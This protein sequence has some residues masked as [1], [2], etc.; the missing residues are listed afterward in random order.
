MAALQQ[1]EDARRADDGD[2]EEDEEGGRFGN[3]DREDAEYSSDEDEEATQSFAPVPPAGNP[4]Y[5]SR[6]R[7]ARDSNRAL[8][9]RAGL[10]GNETESGGSS[11][12]RAIPI[13]SSA[14]T[15]AEIEH[16][17]NQGIVRDITSQE[18][19]MLSESLQVSSLEGSDSRAAPCSHQTTEE[20]EMREALEQLGLGHRADSLAPALIRASEPPVP[21]PVPE[22]P[23]PTPQTLSPHPR[24]HT[25][26]LC[27]SFGRRG[28]SLLGLLW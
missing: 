22:P 12:Y 26:P 20:Q 6:L 14:T 28:T 27:Q 7:R 15:E 17:R 21:V 2:E 23:V 5:Q 1:V 19:S 13:T 25:C 10:V 8:P 3:H 18:R 16:S 24:P 4:A 11:T 9:S